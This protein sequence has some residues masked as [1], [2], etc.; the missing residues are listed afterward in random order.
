M[1]IKGR[2]GGKEGVRESSCERECMVA[3]L[4]ICRSFVLI[5][6]RIHFSEY[7]AIGRKTVIS[8]YSVTLQ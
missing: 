4:L 3:L 5:G 2:E 8:L 6:K 1:H 7:I